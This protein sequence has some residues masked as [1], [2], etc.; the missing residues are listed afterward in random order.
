MKVKFVPQNIELDI[1]PGQSVMEL[2]HANNIPIHST[3][4]GM[5]SCAECRVRVIEGEY[6]VLPPSKKELTLIGTGYYID[7]RRLSCQMHC[8]GDI[9]V[10]TS[11][12]LDRAG[13]GPITKKFLSRVQKS[14]AQESHSVGGVLIEQEE[15]IFKEISETVR[16][17]SEGPQQ[18]QADFLGGGNRP[19]PQGG[20]PRGGDRPRG[21]SRGG[22]GRR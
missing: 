15:G 16:P 6:N 20:G 13:E 21:R 9:T 1:E 2:A 3:C 22:R 5:P 8:F 12:H 7:Q 10:D 19:R 11:E 18:P 14:S 17:P 4:N